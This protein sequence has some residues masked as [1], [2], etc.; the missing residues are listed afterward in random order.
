[1]QILAAPFISAVSA[2]S[3]E[4]IATTV[5]GAGGA[6]VVT[7]SSI[8]STYKHLQLRYIARSSTGG[9]YNP[10]F[11]INSDTAGNY[12]WKY[13][14]GNGSTASSGDSGASPTSIVLPIVPFATSTFGVNIID[15]L[16]YADTNKF[17]TTRNIGGRETNSVGEALV[18]SGLW[19]ST[20][21]I[22]TITLN[23]SGV[24]Q[25]SHF[26]LYGIKG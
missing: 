25:Y 23:F 16:D 8:P 26:A 21:A 12:R 5:V 19:R 6:T 17:K 15:F 24:A 3:Y 7:F 9:E 2:G 13:L 22:S 11:T 20:S 14:T 10:N 4:S 1:M 18:I